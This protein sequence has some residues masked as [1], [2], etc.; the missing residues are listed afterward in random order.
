MCLDPSIMC[1]KIYRWAGEMTR[2]LKCLLCDSE[3]PCLIPRT[4]IKKPESVA[5]ICYPKWVDSGCSLI[6][7]P[8]NQ[9]FLAKERHRLQ[10]EKVLCIWL[11]LGDGRCSIDRC[12]MIFSI[13]FHSV[14]LAKCKW[15]QWW[16][17]YQYDPLYQWWDRRPRWDW[18]LAQG[19]E[20]GGCWARTETKQCESGGCTATA[21]VPPQRPAGRCWD[22]C[23]N[24]ADDRVTVVEFSSFS[25]H[26]LVL[27]SQKGMICRC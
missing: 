10:K 24:S 5:H 9:K 3:D 23:R 19:C 6:K 13:F 7:H 12:R 1:W 21:A 27:V 11:F 18:Y 25:H 15:T 17:A 22:H 14:L 20:A 26:V 8:G 2:E 4:H 16:V